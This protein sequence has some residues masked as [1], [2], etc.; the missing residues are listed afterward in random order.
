V[1]EEQEGRAALVRTGRLLYERHLAHGTAGNLSV[2][3][4]SGEV[5]VTPTDSS[6]GDLDPE[7]IARLS[8]EGELL[9]GDRP[10]KE[11]PFHLAVYAERP[12]AGAV[13]HLH[14]GWSTAVSCLRHEQ[15][16]DVIPPLTAYYVMRVGRLPLVPYFPPGDLALADAVRERARGHRA[17]LLANHGPVVSGASL[18]EAV[19]ASEELEETARLHLLLA[20]RDTAP[21][22]PA[23]VAAL[24][25]RA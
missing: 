20:D 24:E 25:A 23:A 1:S 19:H 21:L 13:V 5:L 11:A 3:L 15:V 8:P 2:R 10:S 18:R 9:D 14:S 7:R 6:L 17:M 22:G 16:D 4:A 12:D